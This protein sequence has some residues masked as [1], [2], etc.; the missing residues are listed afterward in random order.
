MAKNRFNRPVNNQ[1]ISQ[2]V[3]K[4]MNLI[5][6][7]LAGKQQRYDVE[8]N[9]IELLQDKLSSLTGVGE[10]DLNIMS[11]GCISN[12]FGED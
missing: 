4:D 9:K 5:A 10:A 3:P 11:H 8:Q 1:L 7:V 2:F 12:L 6:K